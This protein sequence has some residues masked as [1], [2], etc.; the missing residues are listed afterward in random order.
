MGGLDWYDTF[1]IRVGYSCVDDT[2]GV[3]RMKESNGPAR[4]IVC[5]VKLDKKTNKTKRKYTCVRCQKGIE[6]FDTPIQLSMG[7]GVCRYCKKRKEVFYANEMKTWNKIQVC[8]G[9]IIK[10]GNK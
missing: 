9:C 6:S 1:I 8:P 3:L 2:P 7:V 5:R 4:C 10:E